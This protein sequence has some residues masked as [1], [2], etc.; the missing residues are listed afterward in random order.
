MRLSS[1]AAAAVAVTLAAGAVAPAQT[2]RETLRSLGAGLSERAA[3][4]AVIALRSQA[5]ITY[6]GISAVPGSGRLMLSDLTV[7]PALPWDTQRR[8]TITADRLEIA[9]T[10]L[11]AGAGA[12]LRAAIGA[13]GLEAAIPCLPPGAGG[14]AGMLGV[15]TLRLPEV[16]GDLAYDI[17]SAGAEVTL[18]TRVEGALAGELDARFA[19]LSLDAGRDL[20]EPR[21][22]MRLERAAL[23]V[24]NLGVWEAAQPMLTGML[25]PPLF[26]PDQGPAMLSRMLTEALSDFNDDVGGPDSGLTSAQSAFV[27]SAARAWGGFLADPAQ[28]VIETGLAEGRTVRLDPDAIE[29]DPAALFDALAPRVALAPAPARTLI[30]AALLDR[31]LSEEAS[32]LSKAERRRVALALVTGQG[33]PQNAAAGAALAGAMAESDGDLALAIAEARAGGDPAAAYPSALRAGA[34]GTDGAREALDRIEARLPFARV[35][36]LQHAEADDSGPPPETLAGIRAAAEARMTGQG[37]RRNYA[38]A[39]KWALL[40]QAAGDRGGADILNRIAAR[41]ARDG[42]DGA[43]AWSRTREAAA[44]RATRLWIDTDLPARLGGR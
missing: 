29:D 36:E 2:A 43:A 6:G 13:H 38:D 37:A 27:G 42:P 12:P 25:P 9:G 44:D 33:A 10:P 23:T 1:I 30:P 26:A 4:L 7:R 28:I 20:D 32:T 18:R 11:L 8:C 17:A 5:E 21:P 40:A 41:A 16:T 15:E 24:E 14:M 19:Y 35:L 22:V 31:A 39:A 34:L 3:Q